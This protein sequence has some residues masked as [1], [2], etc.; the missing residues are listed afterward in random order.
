MNQRTADYLN[1]LSQRFAREGDESINSNISPSSSTK[2]V[3]KDDQN[4]E[5]VDRNPDDV[6][7]EPKALP[8]SQSATG[9]KLGK[10][11]LNTYVHITFLCSI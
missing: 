8:N 1:K 7:V 3:T 9:K 10:V 5:I 11:K 6:E 2:C 4:S